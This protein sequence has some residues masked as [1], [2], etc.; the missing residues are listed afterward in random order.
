VLQTF[1]PLTTDEF[2]LNPLMPTRKLRIGL[3]SPYLRK[4]LIDLG[5]DV[6]TSGNHV[7]AARRY[8]PISM[9]NCHHPPNELF[10]G[11]TEEVLLNRMSPGLTSSPVL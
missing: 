10:A 3:G 1:L 5:V 7:W 8:S 11:G 6:I 2:N 9:M 4:E